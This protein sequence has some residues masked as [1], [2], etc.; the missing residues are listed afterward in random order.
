MYKFKVNLDQKEY[1]DFIAKHS[2]ISIMQERGWVQ[3]KNNWD[4]VLVGLYKDEVLVATALLLIR[5]LALNVNL[6][7]IPRGYT[8]D[9]TDSSLVKTFTGYLKD[10]AKERHA[11]CLKIDPLFCVTERSIKENIEIPL[12]FS[13]DYD[14]KHKVLLNNGYIH[15]GFKKNLA[16]YLQPRF[17]LAVPMIDKDNNFLDENT[18]RSKISR[19]TR[20][21]I[22]NYHQ[23]R[24]V[25]FT[26]S[27]D[28]KNIE[29]FYDIINM[30]EK[31]QHIT[32]RSEDY[33]KRIIEA[34][35][36]NA[37]LCFAHVDLVKYISFLESELEVGK[38]NVE[39][40]KRQLDQAKGIKKEYG[41]DVITSVA[42]IISPSNNEGIRMMEYLYAGNNVEILPHLNTN[43]GLLFDIFKKCLDNKIHYCN[44][45]GVGG[46]LDDKLFVFKSKFN[47][48]I[49][50]F[51]GEYDLP[52]NKGIYKLFGVVMPIAKK[53]LKGVRYII[54]R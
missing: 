49:L 22:G 35:K 25:Y 27:S 28:V 52:I 15:K 19:T 26:Y 29:A 47:P 53:V 48:V 17:N 31:R 24:G 3:V 43:V 50:E 46:A 37:Q 33:F 45:G 39:D 13:E 8:I 18:L 44:L 11:Y 1:D 10:Y 14:K 40:T 20:N 38:N 32:L 16:A 41:N 54:K 2:M 30:T 36:D 5:N 6:I 23:K 51:V 42:L 7:Y 34:Y 21:Y 4:N 12:N 9:Y